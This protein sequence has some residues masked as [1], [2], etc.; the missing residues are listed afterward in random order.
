LIDAADILSAKIL[1]VDDLEAG[2][3][4]LKEMLSEAGYTNVASTTNPFE[5]SSLHRAN[6]YK[7][8]LLDLQMP[9]M[10]GFQVMKDL[11]AIE[12]DGYVPVLA[13]TAEPRY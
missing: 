7:V 4:T 3:R 10:N 2:A 1:I 13:I 11:N 9:E 5:V 6:R 12:V 8:I